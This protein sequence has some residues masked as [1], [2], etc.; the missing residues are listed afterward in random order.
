MVL[1]RM[2]GLKGDRRK[3]E[4]AWGDGIKPKTAANAVKSGIRVDISKAWVGGA[5][6]YR[7]CLPISVAVDIV[8]PVISRKRVAAS[9]ANTHSIFVHARRCCPASNDGFEG[10][11]HNVST[12]C[13]HPG[14]EREEVK[15]APL[16]EEIWD[17]FR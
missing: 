6:R 7:N 12:S 4:V 2:V 10:Q 8:F 1:S 17:V 5:A 16:D 14:G 15:S 3:Q 11:G 13:S 9:A